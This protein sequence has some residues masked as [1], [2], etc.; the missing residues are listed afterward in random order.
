[1]RAISFITASQDLGALEILDKVLDVFQVPLTMKLKLKR[2]FLNFQCPTPGQTPDLI[3]SWFE[4]AQK[5]DVDKAVLEWAEENLGWQL[6]EYS[7][8]DLGYHSNRVK[9]TLDYW[10]QF[11]TSRTRAGVCE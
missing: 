3:Q 2:G 4:W 8:C 1:M 9:L 5:T 11:Y 7:P 6:E 10:M